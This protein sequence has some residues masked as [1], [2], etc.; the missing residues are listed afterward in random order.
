VNIRHQRFDIDDVKSLTESFAHKLPVIQGSVNRMMN[1]ELSTKEKIDFIKKA[2]NVRWKSG[3]V[4]SN[5]DVMSILHPRREEDQKNDVWTVF[6]VIQENFT[7]GGLKYVS[8]NG[9]K[10]EL[11]GLKNIMVVNQLNTKLWELATEMC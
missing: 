11:R 4:P 5:L 2:I 1:K 7:R 10:T 6:N 8:D 3:S 9:R